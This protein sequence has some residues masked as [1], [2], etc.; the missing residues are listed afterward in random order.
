MNKKGLAVA[1]AMS[2]VMA[3]AHVSYGAKNEGYAETHQEI[4]EAEQKLNAHILEEK[5]E[6]IKKYSD[7]ELYRD[8]SVDGAVAQL[9]DRKYEVDDRFVQLAKEIESYKKSKS[10][11]NTIQIVKHFNAKA[12][13]REKS[14]KRKINIILVPRVYAVTYSEWA[15]LTTAEKLLAATNPVK[16]LITNTHM[17]NAFIFTK[18]KFGFNGL[19]DKSDGYRRGIW[20]ALMTRDISRSWA[21]AYAT[22]HEEVPQNELTSKQADGF[23]GYQHKAMDLTNNAVGRS[24]VAWYEYFFNLSDTTIKNRISA[25]LINTPG[26]IVWLHN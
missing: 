12:G 1:I 11:D 10:Q 15:A 25:K 19:G 5:D 18:E 6:Q 23:Y 8:E 24:V 14:G 17:N 7:F 21:S 26:N 9:R 3:G 2:V 16:A 13:L 22:A 4:I 20:N